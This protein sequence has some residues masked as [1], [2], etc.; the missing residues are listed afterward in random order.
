MKNIISTLLTVTALS[1]TANSALATDY[2]DG[3]ED[4]RISVSALER[5]LESMGID[6]NTA[7]IEPGLNRA[8]EVKALEGKYSDL[9]DKFNNAHYS[10]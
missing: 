3:V 6:Y 1:V 4:I 7:S 9:Q 10:N 8:Q 5:Q 2:S